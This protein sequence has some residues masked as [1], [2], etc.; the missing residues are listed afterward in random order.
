MDFTC[1]YPP[2]PRSA[3]W[4]RLAESLGYRRVYLH[5]SPAL[6]WDVWAALAHVADHTDEIGLGA[7]VIPHLRHVLT[8]ASAIATIEDLAP[9]RLAVVVGTGFTARAML[10]QR[11][12]PWGRVA[13]FVTSLRA[14]L[15]GEEV[16]VDGR[17]VAMR[18]P[19][20]WA[21]SRPI[22]V[23]IVVAANGPKGLEVAR[24]VGDGVYAFAPT[25]GFAWS[26]FGSAGTVL[27]EG[28][29]VTSARAFDALGPAVALNYHYLYE[30]V[31]AAGVDQL[32]GGPEWRAAVEQVDPSVRHL[33]VHDGH[34]VA[35]NAREL[36]FLDPTLAQ[37]SISGTEREL[38][39]RF[40][41]IEA[42]GATEFAYAPMGSDVPR[43]LRAMAAAAELDRA[44][45]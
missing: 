8:T 7:L 16:E 41:G 10:G 20:G 31:G 25:P 33:H 23:P 12:L 45:R 5:D 9:G 30:T 15:R 14:L 17:L 44:R 3:D 11:P 32:P 38:R 22:D 6:Y 13:R 27:T 1:S 40:A 19:D 36:P 2:G 43:E 29:P 26:I 34:G 37:F 35:P 28:E 24:D 18:H 4:A 21:P 42:G 39:E